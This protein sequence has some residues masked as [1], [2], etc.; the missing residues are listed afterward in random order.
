MLVAASFT[1]CKGKRERK[2]TTA[3]HKQQKQQQQQKKQQKKNQTEKFKN[4][5]PI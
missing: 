4:C 5:F 2:G 1:S 3:P